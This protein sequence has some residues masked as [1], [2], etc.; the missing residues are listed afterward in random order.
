MQLEEF[1]NIY[2]SLTNFALDISLF[3][4]T[5]FNFNCE[6]PNCVHITEIIAK[7]TLD[8]SL[9]FLVT[10]VCKSETSQKSRTRRRLTS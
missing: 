9:H 1:Y 10:Q 3:R 5:L 7:L 6:P 8:Q 4:V 2:Y